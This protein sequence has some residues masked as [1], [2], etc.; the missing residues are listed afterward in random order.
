MADEINQVLAERGG[1]YGAFADQAALAQALKRTMRETP[2]WARLSDAQRE[3]LEMIQHKVA[4]MLNGDPGYQDNAVDICG[5]AQL[6]LDAMRGAARADS[7]TACG[8]RGGE[9][10]A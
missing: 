8:A 10:C 5:Y 6:V 7:G 2:G 3:G 4:R 1:R 9:A